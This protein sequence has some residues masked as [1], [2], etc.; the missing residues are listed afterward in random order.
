[1]YRA[2]NAFIKG[3]RKGEKGA[4]GASL[5][6]DKKVPAAQIPDPAGLNSESVTLH[7]LHEHGHLTLQ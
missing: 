3:V 2:I 7:A 6:E 4:G 1:M 5:P